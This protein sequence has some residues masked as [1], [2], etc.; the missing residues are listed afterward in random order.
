MVSRIGLED[1]ELV[2]IMDWVR[3]NKF[4]DFIWHCANERQCSPQAG[5]LLKRKGVLAGVSDL[6][7]AK[8]NGRFLGLFV[9]LKVAGGKLSSAQ[10]KFLE[11]M[12]ANDYLAVVRYGSV[13]T[14]ATIK[15]YLQLD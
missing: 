6:F 12:N 3:F 2:K 10:S 4:Q 14:I 11:T 13:E 7:V 1:I 8:G 9:E 15:E 5:S